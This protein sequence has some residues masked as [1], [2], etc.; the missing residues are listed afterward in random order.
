MFSPLCCI[1]FFTMPPTFQVTRKIALL[2]VAVALTLSAC[3]APATPAST[4]TNAKYLPALIFQDYYEAHNGLRLLGAAISPEMMENG[5]RVQ[6]FQGGILEYH[7]QLPE[8]NQVMLASIG[9]E[10]YGV[11]PCVPPENVKSGALY[12]SES[13]HS[14]SP[15]F[16]E[17]FQQNG[18]LGFFG[19]PISEM[20]IVDGR[21][22]QNF[23][24]ATIVWDGSKPVG[25]QY[26]Q[27][28]LGSK[29]CVSAQ[30][31]PNARTGAYAPPTATPNPQPTQT[32]ERIT[33]FY[34]AHG[35]IRIFGLPLTHVRRGADGALEQVFE[36]AILYEDPTAPEGVS[37]RPLGLQKLGAP[38]S[39]APPLD[40]PHSGY[41]E[42]YGHNVAYGF[43]DFYTARQGDALFGSPVSEYKIEA[44]RFIQ[45]FENV[46][47]V[48]Y[49]GLPYEQQAQLLDL[50]RQALAAENSLTTAPPRTAPAQSLAV[51]T[52]PARRVLNPNV[53][54]QT[55][56]AWAY[57]Q[58]SLPIA[59]AGVVFTVHT[60]GG[61]MSSTT[62]TDAA[63]LATYT[64][65]LKSY[66]Y[67]AFIIYEAA[68]T[69][70]GLSASKSD[71]FVPWK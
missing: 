62:T 13:C 70:G 2:G 19:Y 31:D 16:R 60:P 38:D 56:K 69:Y 34:Q 29:L 7:P 3:G 42:E 35:A 1:V 22:V 8:G 52:E 49:L 50:G 12:F 54:Q 6:Y 5:V 66:N 53:D 20:Y 32:E 47:V 24:R 39:A 44:D 15:E 33:A 71:S 28:D 58:N 68:V 43:Y 30:C 21:F 10:L 25:F 51:V 18:G 4:L 9:R 61:D 45:Y 63:G 14:V 17:Y 64:F 37:L 67:G 46:V 59:G 27:A 26:G 65:T 23:E 36:N 48:L 41:Y 11:A 55:L 40:D 57:D